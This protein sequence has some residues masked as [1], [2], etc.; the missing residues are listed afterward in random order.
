MPVPTFGAKDR[1]PYL[2]A[3]VEIS[4]HP[5]TGVHSV[6]IHRRAVLGK[7]KTSMWVQPLSHL[8]LMI[9][10]A[11]AQGKGLGV[12][13]VIGAHPALAISSQLK[14]VKGMEK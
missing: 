10:E 9:Q 4:R 1:A 2:T 3:G 5:K 12:A 7:D 8:G 13:T 6:S 11:E 14:V